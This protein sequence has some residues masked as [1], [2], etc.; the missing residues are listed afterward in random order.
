[1]MRF[2]VLALFLSPLFV[3]G[4]VA[5]EV[6]A[7]YEG[8]VTVVEFGV[9]WQQVDNM[10][11]LAMAGAG[12]ALVQC[13]YEGGALKAN[14]QTSVQVFQVQEVEE[15]PADGYDYVDASAGYDD[16][17]PEQVAEAEAE[18]D[19][20]ADE[21]EAMCR[22]LIEAVD[23][24]CEAALCSEDCR[25]AAQAAVA[26]L[27][28]CGAQPLGVA[29]SSCGVHAQSFEKELE[30]VARTHDCECAGH[31][32]APPAADGA[33][34]SNP[35]CEEE[36]AYLRSMRDHR[37]SRAALLLGFLLY[38]L[39]WMLVWTRYVRFVESRH[40]AA[41][42]PMGKCKKVV[43]RL[44]ALPLSACLTQFLLCMV[45]MLPTLVFFVLFFVAIAMRR[46]ALRRRLAMEREMAAH[47]GRDDEENP[48]EIV[49]IEIP[50][51]QPAEGRSDCPTVDGQEVAD[52]EVVVGVPQP[53]GDA[54]VQGVEVVE[55]AQGKEKQVVVADVIA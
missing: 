24:N 4:G 17:A 21:P 48:K 39:L 2:A 23:A 55:D 5:A 49:M 50:A 35:Y 40:A 54:V 27:P 1:M 12:P 10:F 11:A 41:G 43:F 33:Q 31:C 51:E 28:V 46:R 16:A 44:V 53:E 20:G 3:S 29:Y 47:E 13:E 45:A 7:E 19:E 22:E 52:E 15:L 34:V 18:A 8:T 6:G 32:T 37:V 36:E 38:L 42:R 25:A 26:A 14:C 30:I 9:S